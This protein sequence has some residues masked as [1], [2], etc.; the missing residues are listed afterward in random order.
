M[1][2]P[3]TP[4]ERTRAEP[5]SQRPRDPGD[6]RSPSLPEAERRRR[7]RE[8]WISVGVGAALAALF[9][10][11]PIAGL[12]QS[13]ADSG[14]FLFL[15]AVVVILILLLGFLVTR[16]FWKLV[17]ERRRG[18][19]GSH[20]NLKFVSAFV[21]IAFVTASLLFAISAVIVTQSIDRW[22]GVQ[23]D[24]RAREERADRRALLRSDGAAG[25]AARG[26]D[27]R[28]DH[29]PRPAARAEPR[30]ARRPDPH[31]A[32]RLRPRRGRGLR[33]GSPSSS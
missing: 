15:N 8:L 17:A 19:L 11:E 16:S 12:T 33:R 7:R 3:P 27:R 1:P 29:G 24:Q 26:P 18:T 22:F 32:A 14:L 5:A 2:Q 13:V 31:R 30:R 6:E 21:L 9:L 20:L 25:V 28:A 4:Q 10:L 23:V